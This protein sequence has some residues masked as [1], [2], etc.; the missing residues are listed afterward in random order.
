MKRCG[1]VNG[2]ENARTYKYSVSFATGNSTLNYEF[3]LVFDELDRMLP[4]KPNQIQFKLPAQPAA[5]NIPRVVFFEFKPIDLR[6]G[7][8]ESGG[9]RLCGWPH[10]YPH[11]R[12]FPQPVLVDAAGG[13]ERRAAR[14]FG[15]AHSVCAVTF[16]P[17]APGG[18]LAG[19]RI[20]QGF[21]LLAPGRVPSRFIHLFRPTLQVP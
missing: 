20:G 4:E 19:S 7:E 5:T 3:R 6:T 9:R 10:C 1:I 8:Q 17:S 15:I 2:E 12:R 21:H 11:R 18:A 16:Q 13:P 14:S